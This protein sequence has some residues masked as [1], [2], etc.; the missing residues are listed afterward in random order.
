MSPNRSREVA[1]LPV[2]P[3]GPGPGFEPRSARA[4]K[5]LPPNDFCARPRRLRPGS[6]CGARAWRAYPPRG[7]HGLLFFL[8]KPA[9]RAHAPPGGRSLGRPQREQP[10]LLG[11][12]GFASP[13]AG[14]FQLSPDFLRNLLSWKVL[15]RPVAAHLRSTP[16]H[17][18][19]RLWVWGDGRG[20]L[21]GLQACRLELGPGVARR[22]PVPPVAGPALSSPGG[23]L[24]G[25]VRPPA[26]QVALTPCPRS[27]P[28]E[29][30]AGA[31]HL[32]ALAAGRPRGA[33]RQDPL[34]RHLHARG[35][36]AQDQPAGVQSPGARSWASGV[37][38]GTLGLV[39]EDPA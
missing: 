19:R 7:L 14:G 22:R 36:G 17:P 35:G 26:H 2:A 23:A 37:G 1:G 31:H 13:G 11:E 25:L 4:A 29:A 24:G 3:L 34:P 32:H 27:H 9:P 28:A 33:V 18:A 39:G 6:G 15:A 10:G 16:P 30:A 5:R 20:R 12:A 21:R 8:N 38:V